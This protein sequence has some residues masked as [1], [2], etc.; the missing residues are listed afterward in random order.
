MYFSRA[1][2]RSLAPPDW[3]SLNLT[4]K[5]N[6]ACTMCTTCYDA[7]GEMDTD[8]IK[9]VID[10]TAQWGVKVLN[11]LGGEP[12]I[13]K[14]LEE[15]LAY[16]C[17]KDFTI[18][19]TTNATLI[20]KKRAEAL[21][22]IPPSR[23]HFNIS[24]DG[25][26]AIHD[27][28]RGEGQYQ[29]AV[30]GYRHL[31]AA[32][33]AA[34][35][36]HR[37]ILVNTLIHNRNLEELPDFLDVQES[38]GFDGVQLLNLFRHGKSDGDDP[39]GLWI[40]PEQIGA[41]E[42]LVERLVTRV[43]CQGKSG[44][45]ILNPVEDLGL[46]PSYY[47][48][49]LTPLDAPCWSGWK[50]LYIHSDGSA[51]M[52]DG[53]LE[54]LEG[55]FGNVRDQT[56]RQIWSS[57]ELKARREVVKSCTTPCMQGCYLR[58][59]SD[60]IAHLGK[61]ALGEAVDGF[62]GRVSRLGMQEMERVDP[63]ILTLEL[64][65]CA[66][67]PLGGDLAPMRRFEDLVADSPVAFEACWENPTTFTTFRD[68]GYID[69]GRGFLGFDVVRSV[70]EDL[71]RA[72]L[73]FHTLDLSWRGEPLLHPEFAQVL[74]WVLDHGRRHQVFSVLQIRTDGR[75]LGEEVAEVAAAHKE[76][77]QTWVLH[78][79][80]VGE[81]QEGV[82]RNVEHLL[83]IRGDRLRMVPSWVVE[84]SVDA[85]GFSDTWLPRLR[86]PWV[87]AGVL[88]PE[89][90][91]VWFRRSDHDHFQATAEARA[92]LVGVAEDLGIPVDAG[93]EQGPR[94]CPGV[95]ATP[96]VSWDGDITLCPWDVRVENKVGEVTSDR[97][98]RVWQKDETLEALRRGTR[99]RGVPDRDLC[100]DCHQPYS[101]NYRLE[102]PK[103]SSMP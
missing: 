74:D 18:T 30:Q 17:K 32:D 49:K 40:Q 78:G 46:I 54:F 37:K 94:H 103:T 27:T 57:P 91:G 43:T 7:P 16:A 102:K 15:L 98:S 85:Q 70:L 79:N 29:R 41:L 64:S 58:R 68:R 77:D 100:R 59:E 52:C 44:Y 22:R 71:A 69:F 61:Q 21:A 76:I 62:R 82:L 99:G 3:V 19:V 33:A 12:F 87:A 51:I 34:G 86:S 53:Q 75:L 11:P 97:L 20:T 5:C 72:R 24:L 60:S 10:Q 56:L 31:R 39:G 50:E 81:W 23:L 92:R 2:N 8:E 48:D 6:L 73:S 90:D 1:L 45:R 55:R 95:H 38:L 28:I 80:G 65:D 26:E 4:M 9:S 89:G 88:P 63:G 67:W 83:S 14:D 66:P 13:R 101:P 42:D 93:E 25:P 47:R 96:T 35:N 84:G 36:Q